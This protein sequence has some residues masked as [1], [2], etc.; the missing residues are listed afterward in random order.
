MSI[1]K[2]ITEKHRSKLK[3]KHKIP[4]RCNK[5]YGIKPKGFGGKRENHP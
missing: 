3:D 1:L 4:H 2:L 5:F